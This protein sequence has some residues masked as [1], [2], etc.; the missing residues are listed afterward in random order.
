MLRNFRLFVLLL[1][2]PLTGCLFHSHRVQPIPASSAVLRTATVD[3]LV[4]RIN[5]FAQGL[6]TLNA[7]VDID[8][9]VGGAKKGEVTDY[10]QIRGY[11]L[12]RQP[13]L[14]HMI[15]LLPVIRT[16]AFDMVS[17]G[18]EFKLYVPPKNK[19]YEGKNDV[20]MPGATGLAALRPQIIYDALL[21]NGIDPREDIAVLEMG[22]ETVVDPKTHKHVEQS[23]YRLDVI[24]RGPKGW[25][26]E[27]KIYFNRVDLQPW[28]QQVFN[29]EGE[30]ASDVSYSDWK[31]YDGVWFPSAIQIT[32]PIEE[33]EITLSM[34]KVVINEPLS[35][36]QFV[37]NQPPGA[38]VVH[39]A[40]SGV[41]SVRDGSA[42][43]QPRSNDQ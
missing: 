5:A 42:A 32:R 7:T 27:H 43:K 24:H 2:L 22:A 1:G 26:L 18:S 37:L 11:I 40:D 12:V 20:V 3:D 28:R 16:R 29:M 23:D 6:K 21:L 41:A 34:V 33:Y 35:D 13:H 36:Q 4:H 14:L 10:E 15:G 30:T 9:S 19:F 38:Q 39:L 8:T 31:Q 25:Y 17:N